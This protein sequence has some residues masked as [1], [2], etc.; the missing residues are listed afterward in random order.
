ML[1]VIAATYSYND[2][3]HN[4]QEHDE[5]QKVLIYDMH[6]LAENQKI[7]SDNQKAFIDK[8]LDAT[9]REINT[10]LI[11][12]YSELGSVNPSTGQP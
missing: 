6:L 1:G 12:N 8:G 7:L 10:D 9:M 2:A 4:A 3:R 11:N 5:N